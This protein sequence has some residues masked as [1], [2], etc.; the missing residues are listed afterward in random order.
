MNSICNFPTTALLESPIA[1]PYHHAM[2]TTPAV[3]V[4]Q[5]GPSTNCHD[6]DRD[7]SPAKEQEPHG[8]RYARR[9]DNCTT[10]RPLSGAVPAQNLTILCL[11]AG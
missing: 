3:H 4:A 7:P 1:A 10:Q 8:A 2:H 5:R 9:N 11:R 6:D